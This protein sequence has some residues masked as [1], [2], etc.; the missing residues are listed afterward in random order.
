[1]IFNTKDKVVKV[2]RHSYEVQ[3]QHKY[4]DEPIIYTVKFASRDYVMLHNVPYVI[5]SGVSGDVVN[6]D[7]AKCDYMK[8]NGRFTGMKPRGNWEEFKI[9]PLEKFINR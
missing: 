9:M 1:M 7:Y 3:T 4:S 8:V 5:F 6:I 2:N